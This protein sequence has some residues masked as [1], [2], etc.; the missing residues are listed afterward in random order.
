MDPLPTAILGANPQEAKV[1]GKVE[2]CPKTNKRMD[3]CVQYSRPHLRDE[4]NH[5]L[6]IGWDRREW[7]ALFGKSQ[8]KAKFGEKNEH[9]NMEFIFYCRNGQKRRANNNK[10]GQNGQSQSIFARLK[11]KNNP[12]RRTN[13]SGMG[14]IKDDWA[15]NSNSEFWG[16]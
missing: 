11:G 13:S 4:N 14:I 5:H 9:S 10:G 12:F 2:N 16:E 7:K 1:L 8:P 6:R 15:T 3:F